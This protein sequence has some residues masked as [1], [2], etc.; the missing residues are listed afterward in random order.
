MGL[1][2]SG[3]GELGSEFTC[4]FGWDDLGDRIAGF[5]GEH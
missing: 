2:V 3:H 1:G 5:Q 4:G